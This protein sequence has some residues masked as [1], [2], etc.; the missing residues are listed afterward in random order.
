MALQA[1]GVTLGTPNVAGEISV[2]VSN[3]AASIA[4]SVTDTTAL[5][6]AITTEQTNATTADTNVATVQTDLATATTDGNTAVTRA[7]TLGTDYDSLINAMIA[8]TGDTY[9]SVTKQITFGGATG[10]THAQI[11]ALAFNT[12]GT[13]IVTNKTN[14]TQV[15]SDLTTCT[16]DAATAKAATLA[17]KNAANALS[18][19]TIAADHSAAQA[20]I[21][22]ANVYLQFDDGVVTNVAALN[23]GLVAALTFVRHNTIL[24]T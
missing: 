14:T 18:T 12:V 15:Q 1:V 11:A 17:S 13:D 9:N 10:L 6:T 7:T 19:A 20:I 2:T 5:Q 16:N 4:Q 21:A 22:S 3:L 23:G 8:I 24:P